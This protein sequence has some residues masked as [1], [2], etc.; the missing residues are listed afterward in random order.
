[1]PDKNVSNISDAK[2]SVR[3]KKVWTRLKEWYG[4][5]FAE[6]YGDV[7]PED[8]RRLV[9][10]T[11]NTA[12]ARAMQI[13][14]KRYLEFPPTLPQFEQALNPSVAEAKKPSPADLLC[15]WIMRHNSARLTDKQIRLPWD[16]FGTPNG[17]IA[18]VNIPADGDH[19]G[20]RF[21]ITD[22]NTPEANA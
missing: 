10:K 2:V 6:Q 21:T 18:G 17:E 5:R 7:P 16:W 14:R 11:D 9:D 4:Q 13:V 19:Q 20:F 1:M 15:K 3:A 22:M 8:W 12:I